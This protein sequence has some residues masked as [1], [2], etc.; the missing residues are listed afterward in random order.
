MRLTLDSS[1]TDENLSFLQQLGVEHVMIGV[2]T[3]AGYSESLPIESKLRKGDYWESG[4]LLEL[5]KTIESFDLE[6]FG[7]SHTPYHRF[8][9]IIRGL[10]G[11][12][13]QIEDWCKSLRNMG[14]VGIPI[15]QYN[16][17]I[18]AG[19]Q[20]SNWRTSETTPG[21][22]GAHLAS[23][24]YELVKNVPITDFGRISKEEMWSNLAYF[25]K[26]VIPVAAEAGVTMV[27]HP[28][29]PQVPSLAGIDRIMGSVEDYDRLFQM[30]PSNYNAIVFC[31][32]CFSQ[33]LDAD[34]VYEAIR[35]FG[36]RG[37][38]G[39]VHFRN[40]IGTC[41]KFSEVYPDE[42][43]LDMLKVMSIFEEVRNGGHIIPDH[44][45]YGA[46]DTELG[47]RGFAFAIGY[48]KGLIQA[49]S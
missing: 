12:D 40:V 38:I 17:H 11:G 46:G 20:F 6:L 36:S 24:D 14:R 41:E 35:H 29:D 8:E 48:M 49:V 26:A 18:N 1:L 37:K 13:K 31:L 19:A 27:V 7:L 23:F 10:P 2:G 43:K 4:D 32:G 3:A 42:G 21:R 9:K 22:G 15:L 25:L 44:T 45:P 16:W 33:I 34:E 28:A 39:Y 47:H 30:V 5:K